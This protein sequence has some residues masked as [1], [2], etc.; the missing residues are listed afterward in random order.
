MGT[1]YD[2]FDTLAHTDDPRVTGAPRAHRQ[3]LKSTLESLGFV[4]LA[5]EW[6]HYTYQP[7]PYPDTYF[8]FP[9]SRA[10]LPGTR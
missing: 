7:E 5:E 2:C 8:D 4:N 9:V 3:L 1:G 10:A 6:W